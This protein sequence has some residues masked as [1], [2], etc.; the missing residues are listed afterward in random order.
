MACNVGAKTLVVILKNLI[1]RHI[2]LDQ[3]QLFQNIQ[4][5]LKI[6]AYQ[7]QKN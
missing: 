4:F 2:I 7:N 6:D 3:L 1:N 5:C